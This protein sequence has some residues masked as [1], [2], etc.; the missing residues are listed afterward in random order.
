MYDGSFDQQQPQ[1]SS[2]LRMDYDQTDLIRKTVDI[3]YLNI[4]NRL[5]HVYKI[6]P[7]NEALS[8]DEYGDDYANF[9]MIFETYRAN[10]NNNNGNNNNG[11]NIAIPNNQN[12]VVLNIERQPTTE[13]TLEDLEERLASDY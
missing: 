4:I 12:A 9:E 5:K 3:F 2:S 10:N 13:L 11:N 8:V 6:I 7:P 1:L